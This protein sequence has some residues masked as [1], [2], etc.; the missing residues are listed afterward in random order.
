MRMTNICI[1]MSGGVD[2]SAAAS[3]IRENYPAC[4]GMTLSMLGGAGD[5]SNARDAAQVCEKL[6]IPHHTVDCRDIFRQ[7]VMEYFADTYAKGL[8]PNPCV[9]CN[10][11][12]KFGFLLICGLAFLAI[13][14]VMYL[15]Y[16]RYV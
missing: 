9:V 3:L 11:E 13:A 8:T 10:R 5:E 16:R 14:V 1:A 4:G 2:S 12:I 7:A 6:G 15:L